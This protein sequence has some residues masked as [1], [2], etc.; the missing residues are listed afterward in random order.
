[1]VSEQHATQALLRRRHHWAGL[2]CLVYDVQWTAAPGWM[3]LSFEQ[4]TLCFLL[5]AIGVRAELRSKPDIPADGEYFGAD[6]LTFLAAEVPITLYSSSLRR[7]E[8]VCFVLRPREAG[9]LT[10]DQV[11]LIGRAPSRLMFQDQALHTCAKMLSALEGDDESDAYG[12]GLRHGLLAALLGTVS[13]L[14]PPTQYRLTGLPLERVLTH[15]LEHL[16]ERLTNE[17]LAQLAEISPKEFGSTF[18]EATGL[19]PQRWQMDARVRL[20]QQLMVDD[21]SLSLASIAVR[22][23]FAD[24]SHFSRAFLDIL[25][26]TPTAWLHQRR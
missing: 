12:R 8:F 18:R 7:A 20:A 25:G 15:L 24:Q 22:A 5:E 21:P 6:H 11:E 3:N 26:A 16:Q 1:M 9:C 10:V 2:S 4:P 13:N 19:S 14:P 23:G 17:S